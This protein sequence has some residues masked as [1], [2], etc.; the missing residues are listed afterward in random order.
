MF[1][2]LQARWS[3]ISDV[4]T[5]NFIVLPFINIFNGTC[6]DTAMAVSHVFFIVLK[7]SKVLE[8]HMRVYW[9]DSLY[10]DF[11]TS[12]SRHTV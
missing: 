5:K 6:T 8:H 4:K 3:I 12:L 7:L 10:K 9:Y 11:D 2:K 1:P